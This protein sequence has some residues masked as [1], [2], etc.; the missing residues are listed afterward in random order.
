MYEWRQK[1]REKEKWGGLREGQR[2]MRREEE[3]KENKEEL[4]GEKGG[5]NQGGRNQGEGRRRRMRRRRE[6]AEEAGQRF[7]P[8][9]PPVASV[10]A[11]TSKG[12]W[13]MEEKMLLLEI[14]C[15]V[16]SCVFGSLRVWDCLALVRLLQGHPPPRNPS[17]PKS[18]SS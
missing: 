4:R 14:L 13:F 16:V 3:S 6:E 1:L 2:R 12:W 5:R 17:I 8:V 10:L 15:L 18:F 9:G 11:G 7:S